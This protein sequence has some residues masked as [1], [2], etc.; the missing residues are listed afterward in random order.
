MA[1][2]GTKGSAQTGPVVL[3]GATGRLGGLVAEE[4]IALGAQV[5]ALVRP[6]SAVGAVDALRETGVETRTVDYDDVAAL[7][8]G[9]ADAVCV[10]SALAGTRDVIVESQ[11][12]L[13]DAAV[14]AGVPRFIPSDYALDFTKTKPGRNRNLDNRRDFHG[15]L[16][17]APIRATSVLCGMFTDILNGPAPLV[18][19]DKRRVL[20][21]GD[22]DQRMDFTTMED[23]A[24]F[25][26]RA[27]LDDD[28]PRFLRIAG[29]SASARELA[30][31]AAEV[32]GEPFRLTRAGPIVLLSAMINAMRLA[33]PAKDQ[34]YPP[35]Q[36]MQYMRDMLEG[37]AVLEPLD[38][39]RYGATEWTSV[40][41]VLAD[42]PYDSGDDDDEQS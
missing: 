30:G 25:T 8:D 15:V 3:A 12:R 18:M 33:M 39:D 19:F 27:A 4:L 1:K 2:R 9:C 34:T 21:W 26:A 20:Y 42:G 28:A 31:I 17:G 22:A 10:V 7:A 37:D 6:E 13:L 14:R 35:W 5:R 40:A 16:D 24:W 11:A 41:D 23:T 36:G 38:N 32:A 29:D